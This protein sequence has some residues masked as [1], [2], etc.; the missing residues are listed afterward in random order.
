MTSRALC[1][2]FANSEDKGDEVMA[3]PPDADL[4]EAEI[5]YMI[6]VVGFSAEDLN[7]NR[8]DLPEDP[9][10]PIFVRNKDG[11][12]WSADSFVGYFLV[13]AEKNIRDFGP[14]SLTPGQVYPVSFPVNL[15][16]KSFHV[17]TDQGSVDV[18]KVIVRV[19][20]RL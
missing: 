8:L 10:Q 12:Q 7:G 16:Q 5:P 15:P 14:P 11:D 1:P 4:H 6:E 17:D 13:D 19:E 2:D 18:A 9:D 3:N 20:F